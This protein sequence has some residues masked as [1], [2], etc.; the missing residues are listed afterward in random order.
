MANKLFRQF[1]EAATT[2]GLSLGHKYHLRPITPESMDAVDALYAENRYKIKGEIY[3]PEMVQH[4]DKISD[5]PGELKLIRYTIHST[6]TG[7]VLGYFSL[8]VKEHRANVVKDFFHLPLVP[9]YP[10][11]LTLLL[12]LWLWSSSGYEKIYYTKNWGFKGLSPLDRKIGVYCLGREG[13]RAPGVPERHRYYLR[14][15][16]YDGN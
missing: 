5:V 8:Q 14:G 15:R 13:S 10:P 6:G 1:E 11:E 9:A 4:F 12:K 3:F 16:N 7:E 2:D